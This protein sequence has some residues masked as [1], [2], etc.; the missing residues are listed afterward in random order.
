MIPMKVYNFNHVRNLFII[1]LFILVVTCNSRENKKNEKPEETDSQVS[2]SEETGWEGT[3]SAVVNLESFDGNRI[4][5]SGQGFFVAADIIA[6]KYALVSQADSVA[7]T[8]LNTDK[9]YS[10]YSYVAFDRI[11]DIILLKVEGLKK[12]PVPLFKETVPDGAKTIY[13]SV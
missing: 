6:T 2:A 9:A 11:N 12:K 10:S 4:L 7:V 8:P 13:L 3:I 1:V 5:E